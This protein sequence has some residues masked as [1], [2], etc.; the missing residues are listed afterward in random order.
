MNM[1][2]R[3]GP[4]VHTAPSRIF[5]CDVVSGSMTIDVFVESKAT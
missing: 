4:T 2:A 1:V 5:T 3:K